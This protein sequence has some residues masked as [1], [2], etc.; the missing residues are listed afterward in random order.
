MLFRKNVTQPKDNNN[1]IINALQAEL[2]SIANSCATIYFTPEGEVVD[3]SPLFLSTMGY[4]L[5]EIKGQHHRLFCPPEL[6]DKPQY[7]QFWSDLA[8]GKPQRGT[9]LRKSKQGHDVWLEATY[10]PIEQDGR[11]VRIMKIAND[12]TQN[13][14]ESV[15]DKALLQAIHRSNAVIEFTVDGRVI[16]A[17]D[18]FVHALGYN[19]LREIKGQHHEIFCPPEF[20]KENPTFWRDLANGQVKNGLFR[21]VSRNGDNVWIEA[22]YNPVFDHRGKVIKVTKIA[23]DITE[24]M[25]RQMAIQKAAEVAHRTSVETAQVSE[26]GASILKQNLSNSEKISSDI[27]RSSG[28]VDDLNTQSEE[29]SKIVTTIK[30]IADQTNLLA[31]NAA[32]EAARAGDHGRGF[33]VVADEVRTLASRTTRSTEEINTM[34]DRNNQLVGNVRSSMVEVT[35]QATRNADLIAEASEII[36]EIL[37]GADYVSHVVGDLVNSSQR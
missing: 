2:S 6:V 9:F 16:D 8:K 14:E 30:S 33:A 3:A 1:Q 34:V 27:R 35:E 37:K 12:I 15:D 29:I 17:N 10:I 28:L 18:N 21:R 36:H 22:T 26:R 7:H 5:D 25:E 24:R 32:I 13:F 23:C 31:L 20:Y 4:T 11:V 19:E